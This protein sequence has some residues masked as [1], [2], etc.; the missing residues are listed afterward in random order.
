M[1]KSTKQRVL[2]SP[3]DIDSVI[4]METPATAHFGHNGMLTLHEAFLSS[5]DESGE[6]IFSVIGATQTSG[7]YHLLFNE[8]NHEALDKIMIDVDEKLDAIGNWN[9][10]SA[11]Y[12][13]IVMD[14]V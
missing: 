5:K 2:T 7:T 11:N 6:P 14:D 12:R 1:L 13:Y 8:K 9:D 10:K 3:N 4:E